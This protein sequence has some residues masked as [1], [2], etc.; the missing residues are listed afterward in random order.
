MKSGDVGHK[1][2]PQSPRTVYRISRPPGV[3]LGA[4]RTTGSLGR[5][6]EPAI[7]MGRGYPDHGDPSQKCPVASDRVC[8]LCLLIAE[9]V[10]LPASPL[11]E[12][13]ANFFAVGD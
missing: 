13:R 7:P 2:E 9:H 8:D 12:T 5:Q 11:R 3:K 10:D 1:E 6:D 4:G